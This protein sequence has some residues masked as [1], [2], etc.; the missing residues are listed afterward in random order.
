MASI[1]CVAGTITGVW[2]GTPA[3]RLMSFEPD[4]RVVGQRRTLLASG[5]P[6]VWAYRTD[7][8]ASFELRDIPNTTMEAALAVLAH[9]ASGGTFTVHTDDAAARSYPNCV[10][11]P[12]ADPPSLKLS[13]K[14]AL[15]YSVAVTALN[16]DGA[17]LVAIY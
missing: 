12:D 13:D 11:A 3:D 15:R 8:V 7:F 1:E 10:L 17:P 5:A 14:Q 4:V 16:L 9:I 2:A 6:R